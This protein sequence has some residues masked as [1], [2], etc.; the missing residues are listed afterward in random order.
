[1]KEI[2]ISKIEH[3]RILGR[4]CY[5]EG[6]ETL[7]LFWGGAALE[8]NVKAREV[9]VCLSSDYADHEQW[10]SVEING[11]PISRFMVNKEKTLYCIV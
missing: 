1:M 5:R 10:I 2:N 7:S 8:I 3:K 6:D 9:Y 4:N 11:A